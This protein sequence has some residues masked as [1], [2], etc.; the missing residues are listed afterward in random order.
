[1]VFA[2]PDSASYQEYGVDTSFTVSQESSEAGP[3]Y[4]L[5][6]RK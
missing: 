3:Y 1:V 2:M 6:P 5:Q 4:L